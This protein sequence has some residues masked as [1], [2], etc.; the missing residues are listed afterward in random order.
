MKSIAS[1][2]LDP[3]TY[4]VPGF[5]REH[6]ISRSYLYRLWNEGRGPRRTKV[7]RR[8]LSSGE[9]AAAWRR[10]MEAET[11]EQESGES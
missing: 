7:G 5:C 8:T 2:F 1:R 6:H 9:A 10:R 3:A 11:T 4:T